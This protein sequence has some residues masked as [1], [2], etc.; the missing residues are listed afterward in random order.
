MC[1]DVEM[2]EMLRKLPGV[3]RQME[4]TIINGKFHSIYLD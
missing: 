1:V 3:E 4:T 2:E